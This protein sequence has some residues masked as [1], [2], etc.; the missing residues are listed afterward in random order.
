MSYA[1][2]G[3]CHNAEPGTYGHECGKPAQWLGTTPGGFAAGFCDDCKR[4]GHEA[5]GMK[6][7]RAH[8]LTLVQYQDISHVTECGVTS[9]LQNPVRVF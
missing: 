5:R 8:P 3:K 7:W 4:N 9:R 2:D 6:D 1:T